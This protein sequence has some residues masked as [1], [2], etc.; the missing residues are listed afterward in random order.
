MQRQ[1][2]NQVARIKKDEM[3]RVAAFVELAYEHDPRDF[4]KLLVKAFEHIIVFEGL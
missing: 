1:N 3:K 4:S 2:A